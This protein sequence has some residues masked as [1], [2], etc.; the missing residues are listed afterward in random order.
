M[1]WELLQPY[2]LHLRGLGHCLIIRLPRMQ[3]KQSFPLATNL[4]L[5][6]GIVSF[7]TLHSHSR[8]VL[9][10]TMQ[11][12]I[13]VDDFCCKFWWLFCCV[14]AAKTFNATFVLG[15]A[16]MKSSVL[17]LMSVLFIKLCA[18]AFSFNQSLKSRKVGFTQLILT[19]KSHHDSFKFGGSFCTAVLRCAA[20][21]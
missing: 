8:W 6:V 21:F 1:L 14:F 7:K 11:L 3:E 16:L 9:L 15:T 4:D 5:C 19:V 10:H 18:S 20:H 13:D 17:V 12:G 2:F